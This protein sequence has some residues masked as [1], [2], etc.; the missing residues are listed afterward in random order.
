MSDCGYLYKVFQSKDRIITF[1]KIT[2]DLNVINITASNNE[3]ITYNKTRRAWCH[4]NR[5]QRSDNHGIIFL[6]LYFI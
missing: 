2:K 4:Q 6:L 3:G 1:E 5:V